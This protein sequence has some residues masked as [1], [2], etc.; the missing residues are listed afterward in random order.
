MEGVIYGGRAC[1]SVEAGGFS[2]DR[3]KK[4]R[5]YK[6]W[7]WSRSSSLDSAK[8]TAASDLLRGQAYSSLSSSVAVLSAV[9]EGRD[10]RLYHCSFSSS[11][12][13]HFRKLEPIHLRLL[14]TWHFYGQVKE[15][16]LYS[17]SLDCLNAKFIADF[18]PLTPILSTLSF[19][20]SKR[21]E[22][23]LL[24]STPAWH[25]YGLVKEKTL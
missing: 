24:N 4:D 14:T 2:R 25:F 18:L 10:F 11:F 16:T 20:L 1:G 6:T 21:T 9:G 23:I 7:W 22:A 12:S 3:A 13:I 8:D 17:F 15:K 5:H 19:Q